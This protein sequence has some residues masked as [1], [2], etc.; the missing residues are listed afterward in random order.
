MQNEPEDIEKLRD[1]LLGEQQQTVVEL[2]QRL[3]NRYQRTQDLSE[4]L[5]DAIRLTESNDGND[6]K[7]ALS[8]PVRQSVQLAIEKDPQKFADALYPSILPAIR[9]A[10]QEMS[11]QFIEQVDKALTQKFTF[12]HFQWRIESWRTGVPVSAI[13]LRESIDYEVEQ[14]LLIQNGSGLLQA[15]AYRESAKKTDS[16]AVSGMLWAI[17]SFVRDSFTKD[18]EGLNRVTMGE[19][20][21][22]LV[23][24]PAATLAS[25]V[26][27]VAP[28]AYLKQ[29]KL[30]LEAIHLNYLPQLEQAPDN[31]VQRKEWVGPLETL[32]MQAQSSSRSGGVKTGKSL[33]RLLLI[34][35]AVIF[36]VLVFALLQFLESRKMQQSL[37]Q[38][39]AQPGISILTSERHWGK[40][41]VSVLADPAVG[42]FDQLLSQQK[43]DPRKIDLAL[44]PFLSLEPEMAL[45]RVI[46]SWEIPAAVSAKI[47]NGVLI[48]RGA[49][50]VN[51]YI[52]LRKMTMLPYG[53]D[54]VDTNHIVLKETEVTQYL[55]EKIGFPGSI[56]IETQPGILMFS[57][58]ATQNWITQLEAE[59]Q[60]IGDQIGFDLEM[61]ESK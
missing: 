39:D 28:P 11:R 50:P 13:M 49:A 55:E 3:T 60:L 17:E 18:N 59:I 35:G 22:Y 4:V 1:L 46:G 14:L 47:H 19:H 33:R 9:R 38:L 26:S 42:D 61:L 31:D 57:G 34:F 32:L 53:I 15:H 41:E 29:A 2:K 16:S 36:A 20:T 8:V 10:V 27:G 6:L 43:I 37:M 45:K 5:A 21:L 7:E 23:H 51:W 56:E 44:T 24:G 40:W 48:L 12:R 54:A 25:V 30:T 58:A 52:G